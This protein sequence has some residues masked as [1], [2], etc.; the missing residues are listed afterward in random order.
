[1]VWALLLL[2]V[3]YALFPLIHSPWQAFLLLGAAGAGNGALW[4]A[5]SSLL[6]ALTPPERRH[7]AFALNRM[8]GNLGLGIGTVT[9]GLIATTSNSSSF[10]VLFLLN[11]GTFLLFALCTLLVREA[12]PE[13]TPGHT[14][15]SYR[16]VLRDRPFV[17]F[18]LLNAVFVA[19]GY[20][21]L[22][23]ALPVF[24]KHEAGLAESAIGLLFLAN[25]LVIVLAQMPI[26]RLIE[27]RRRMRVLGVMTLIWAASWLIAGAAGLW[28]ESVSAAL[29]LGVAVVAFGFGECLHG[30]IS[31]AVAADL[32]PEQMRGRYMALGSSSF[33]IGFMVGPVLAGFVLGMSPLALWPLIAAICVAAGA[34]CLL[35]ERKLP[36]SAL[37]TP[38]RA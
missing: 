10:T 19:A 38:A 28:F 31:S 25:I 12:R 6:V 21:Q 14:R 9:G 27:G 18:T 5:Q 11:A 1:M 7:G 15:G 37:R 26:S 35:L 30:P 3:A 36:E 34:W 2:T 23:A 4:P 22:E 17:A 32:A 20:A 13:R 29:L 8:V 33:A 16:T 24:A